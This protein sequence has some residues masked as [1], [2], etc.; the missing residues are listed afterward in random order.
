M[1]L[2]IFI[3]VLARRWIAVLLV[4]VVGALGAWVVTLLSE[5][6]YERELSFA[7]VPGD[8][9]PVAERTDILGTISEPDSAITESVVAILESR[10][11][12]RETILDAGVPPDAGYEFASSRRPGST[13]FDVQ[14]RGPDAEELAALGE[15][16][17]PTAARRVAE[18]LPGLRLQLLGS[19]ASAD[20]V[21][22]NVPV[23]VAFGGFVGALLGLGIV[24]VEGLSRAR[25]PA[26]AGEGERRD[27][28]AGQ[29]VI[30]GLAGR[31]DRL[32]EAVRA[33]LHEDEAVRRVGVDRLEVV[34]TDQPP[35]DR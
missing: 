1:S 5:K 8:Y 23:M 11:V 30:D 27:D 21:D 9:L 35:P 14:L 17:T 16:L 33:H 20:P 2:R 18:D 25:R 24:L 4:I 28:G 22:P 31:M 12:E 15:A 10:D 26:G 6:R 13:V 32:E 3:D 7:L 19:E 29:I 34:K